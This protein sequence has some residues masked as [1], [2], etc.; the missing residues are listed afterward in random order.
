MFYNKINKNTRYIKTE[1]NL[2]EL[3]EYHELQH[4]VTLSE[5]TIHMLRQSESYRREAEYTV[6]VV[7]GSRDK[8]VIQVLWCGWTTRKLFLHYTYQLLSD[9]I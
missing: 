6:Q 1:A 7:S 4:K 2:C 5:T 3:L 9:L 8:V